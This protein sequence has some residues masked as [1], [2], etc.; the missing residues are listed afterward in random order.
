MSVMMAMRLTADPA[1]FEEVAR[2]KGEELTSIA[3]RAKEM[4]AIHHLFMAGDREVIV[5][6]EWDSEE[7]FHAFFE[8]EGERIGALMAAAGVSNE[9][10]PTFTRAIDTPDRF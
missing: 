9:P 10:Q 3:A 5:A 2:E 1:R 6:D 4:G 8:A 7:S